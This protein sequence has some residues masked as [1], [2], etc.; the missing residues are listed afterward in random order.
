MSSENFDTLAG[1]LPP[2]VP[3]EPKPLPPSSNPNWKMIGAI[4]GVVVLSILVLAIVFSGG[5]GDDE[6]TPIAAVT[7]Q[8]ERTPVAEN[9]TTPTIAP[10]NTPEPTPTL[11]PTATDT[12]EPT[13]T[14]PPPPTATNTP[15]PTATTP[16]T[17]TP[18]PPSTPVPQGLVILAGGTDGLNAA[19]YYCQEAIE[20]QQVGTFIEMGER[21][22]E[23]LGRSSNGNWV[24]V[25]HNGQEGW[26]S[27]TP[28]YVTV[29]SGS[30]TADLEVLPQSETICEERSG[31]GSTT[32]TPI[33]NGGIAYWN[34]NANTSTIGE[35]KWKAEFT[36]RVP[37]GPVPTIGFT[38]L[39]VSNL[40]KQ[41]T[42]NGY[43]YYLISVSGMGCSGDLVQRMTVNQGGRTLTIRQEGTE[44]NNPNIFI[45]KPANCS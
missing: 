30:I 31:T 35:G 13:A 7:T 4:I 28:R 3:P 16:A 2:S 18:R 1:R 6:P 37:S 9:N 27:A 34:A 15:A 5:N 36:I 43:D 11:A 17:N 24:Y 22:D 19:L 38:G 26:I 33:V 39:T 25:R 21:I 8:A 20:S 41:Q 14:N 40:G 29:Q 32:E 42:S 23:L 12:P 45:A 44:T 10:T